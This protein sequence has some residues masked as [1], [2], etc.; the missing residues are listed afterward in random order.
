[1]LRIQFGRNGFVHPTLQSNAAVC[2]VSSCSGGSGRTSRSG[3]GRAHSPGVAWPEMQAALREIWAYAGTRISSAALSNAS[4]RS[5]FA[6]KPSPATPPC[7]GSGGCRRSP[8]IWW[9]QPKPWARARSSASVRAPPERARARRR[10]GSPRSGP[11]RSQLPHRP[12]PASPTRRR[13]RP[14][15][16]T[17]PL[18]S[19]SCPLSIRPASRVLVR[20]D[21][22]SR[23]WMREQ[24][25]QYHRIGL[26]ERVL[27]PC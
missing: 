6:W 18:F 11:A 20:A 22:G 1:M 24:G 4:A 7:A 25:S 9:W 21:P 3:A 27:R 17:L 13:A 19:Y 23:R 8:A 12:P 14:S 2:S 5:R 16:S 26:A 15:V 10:L